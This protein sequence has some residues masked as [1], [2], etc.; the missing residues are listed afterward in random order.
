MM[1]T[2]FLLFILLFAYKA[3]AQNYNPV[4]N[5]NFN[6]TPVH[7]IKIKTNIPFTPA[8]HLPTVIIEGYS[9]G[10]GEPI[11]LVLNWYTYSSSSDFFNDASGF[12]FLNPAISSFGAYAPDVYLAAENG[13]V[14]IYIDKK[15]YYQ[16][17]TVRAYAQGMSEQSTWF[18][19]WTTSDEPNTGVK[20]ILVPYKNKF[21]GDILLSGN[22]I[23][24][25]SGN[26]GIGTNDPKGYKLAVAGDMIAES[27][28]IKL[29]SA[30]PDFVFAKSYKLPTLQETENH[31]I[32]RG[33]LPGIPTAAEVKVNGI[34]LGDMNAKLLQKIEEL[35]LHL[36]EKDKQIASQEEQNQKQEI[37]IKKLE[38][39]FQQLM[40]IIQ[41]KQL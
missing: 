1:R 14:I 2:A 39:K 16:R 7:G 35:T 36:I 40:K 8:A 6:G 37:S 27:V 21:K 12:Y 20:S 28:K 26:V 13:K 23:W 18:Q 29:Q 15:D 4:L 17:F 3:E 33:H 25:S 19:G 30:W 22:G 10:L 31:I 9:F 38:M 41:S 5:Y 11:G 32:K 34:D 24:N